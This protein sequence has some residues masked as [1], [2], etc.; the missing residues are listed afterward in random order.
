LGRRLPSLELCEE[1]S[2]YESSEEY[3]KFWGKKPNLSW[4]RP[5]GCLVYILVYKDIRKRKF[6][7][8]AIPTVHLGASEKHA[9]YRV[10]VLA[11]RK[12]KVSKDVRFYEDIFPFCMEPGVDLTR[13]NP[14]DCPQLNPDLPAKTLPG[15]SPAPTSTPLKRRAPLPPN[16]SAHDAEHPPQQPMVSAPT[17]RKRIYGPPPTPEPS[18][19]SAPSEPDAPKQH[20]QRAGAGSTWKKVSNKE[21][22]SMMKDIENLQISDKPRSRLRSRKFGQTD[23]S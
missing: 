6:D 22:E 3:E 21:V 7:T 15:A 19:P 4:I 23:R 17:K 2:P 5:F 1:Q 12:S 14:V 11:D 13:L 8:S 16:S 10:M 9:A 18:E 20:G